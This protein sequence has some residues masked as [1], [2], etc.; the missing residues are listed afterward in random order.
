MSSVLYFAYGSNLDVEQMLER[1]PSSRALM[2][3]C[4]REHRLEFTHLSRRWGG[5]AADI[6]PQAGTDVWGGL[7]QLERPELER[8]RSGSTATAPPRSGPS[9]TRLGRREPSH[10]RRS[11]WPRCS[12]GASTGVSPKTTSTPS[13]LC[14]RDGGRAGLSR[15]RP[16]S[17]TS[18][19]TGSEPTR[20]RTRVRLPYKRMADGWGSRRGPG[21]STSTVTGSKPTRRGTRVRRVLGG[22]PTRPLA[23]S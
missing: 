11:T 9:A 8:S 10:Q 18:T 2:R 4:L 12:T 3:A 15:R 22:S 16:G 14:T 7:Y 20:G 13:E 1:C 6:L 5:G 17:S 19:V 23:E 21:S